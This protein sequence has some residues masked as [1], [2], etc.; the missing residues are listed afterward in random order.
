MKFMKD[1]LSN[2]C[3]LEEFEIIALTKECSAILQK[4]LAPKM[5]DLGCFCIPCTIGQCNIE[6]ALCDLRAN[7]NLMPLSV[8]KKLG[9]GEVKPITISLLLADRLIKHPRAVLEKV[10]VKVDKFIFP[11]DFIILYMEED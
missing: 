9:L 6:R 5:K 8:Y 2:K 10:L 1:I 3:K 11:T 7:V 4:K